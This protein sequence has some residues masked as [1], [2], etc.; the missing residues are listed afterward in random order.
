MWC[1]SNSG[2]PSLFCVQ[3]LLQT[4]QAHRFGWRSPCVRGDCVCS[5]PFRRWVAS[6]GPGSP[7]GERGAFSPGR[8][9]RDLWCTQWFPVAAVIN[10][11]E[12]GGLKE[13]EVLWLLWR[14][15]VWNQK[16]GPNSGGQE[17]CTPG[18]SGRGFALCLLWH[19]VAVAFPG[20][21]SC[22]STLCLLG[23][24]ASCYSECVDHPSLKVP[25][26]AFR[27]HADHLR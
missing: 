9:D 21:W 22:G 20:L 24:M 18:G 27:A 2:K 10:C 8:I 23:H 16:Q 19:L 7:K 6:V 4:S 5:W 17:G 11:H 1:I 3:H 12:L 14:T 25:G 13:R 15:E 26:I